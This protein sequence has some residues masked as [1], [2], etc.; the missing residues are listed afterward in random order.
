[1][2]KFEEAMLEEVFAAAVRKAICTIG[3]RRFKETSFFGSSER[4]VALSKAA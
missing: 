4:S 1:M 3:L 2:T